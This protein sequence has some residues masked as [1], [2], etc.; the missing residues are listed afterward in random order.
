MFSFLSSIGPEIPM[1]LLLMSLLGLRAKVW[2]RASLFI[3]TTPEKLFVLLDIANGKREDWGRTT[4]LTEL[5]DTARGIFRKTY[6]T[7]LASGVSRDSSA[8]FSLRRREP[9]NLLE[10]QREGIEGKS[11]NNELLSQRYDITAEGE[12]ARL[13]MTYEWGPRPLVAQLLARADLWG[14]IYRLRGLAERGVPNDRPYQL[15]SG[16]VMI[17]TGALSLGAFAMLVGWAIAGLL[18]A[19]LFVH[20]LGHLLAYRMMGQPWGRMIFLPFLG[21]MALPRMRFDSQ[22]QAVFAALMGPGFSIL[23]ALVCTIHASAFG[24]LGSEFL[25]QL[26]L[27]AVLLNIFNLLPAEPL[28]GGVALRSVLSRLLGKY[29]RYGLIAVGLLIIAAGLYWS[30]VLLVLF[31]G[32]AIVL[33]LRT[34]NIDHGLIPL[35]RLQVTTSLFCYCFL[36]AAYVKLFTFYFELGNLRAAV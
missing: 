6:T 8:L 4:I 23:L 18:I 33:N 34:R 25:M 9:P 21:A 17:L 19:A 26:G 36:V 2:P 5:T 7:T 20:E 28:D 35:S 10:I 27:V 31:G 3:R 16:G 22:G 30:F 14:G 1:S 24:Q 29:A 13:T 32:I 12:G 15:I 11:L